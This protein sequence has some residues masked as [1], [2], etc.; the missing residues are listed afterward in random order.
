MGYP[1][2]ANGL[3]MGYPRGTRGLLPWATHGLPVGRQPAATKQ[4]GVAHGPSMD[5]PRATH[6]IPVGCQRAATKKYGIPMGCS[7]DAHGLRITYPWTNHGVG[8]PGHLWAI[9]QL[10]MGY[11]HGLSMS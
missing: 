1:W 2:G 8:N 5:Y 11:P 7:W 6:G 4:H 10:S 3:S 9:N